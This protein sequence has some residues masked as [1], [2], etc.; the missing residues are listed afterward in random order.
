[1]NPVYPA[2]F[3]HLTGP[4]TRLDF[5]DM[6]FPQEVHTQARLPYSA[7]NG[8]RQFIVQQHFVPHQFF[9][10]FQSPNF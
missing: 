8:Q 7:S 6:G 2:L 1:M 3:E 10:I 4:D 5:T 9:A